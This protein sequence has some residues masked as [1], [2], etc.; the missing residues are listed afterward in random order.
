LKHAQ[1]SA[2]ATVRS[3]ALS[4]GYD[5]VIVEAQRE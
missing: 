3:L 5:V 1:D 2:M 4:L